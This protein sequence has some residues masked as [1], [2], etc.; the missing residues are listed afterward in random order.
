MIYFNKFKIRR[1][2]VRMSIIK[3]WSELT[4]QEFSQ[5]EYN[6]FWQDYFLKEQNNYETI[7]GAKNTALKGTVT[8]LAEKVRLYNSSIYLSEDFFP[9]GFFSD[10]P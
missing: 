3:K 10:L 9:S 1:R 7:L 5:E 4:D 2:G 8:D 6:K